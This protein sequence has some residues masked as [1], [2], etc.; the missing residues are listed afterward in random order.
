MDVKR[1]VVTYY[2]EYG[3]W[4]QIA[5]EL[6]SRI[7]L[8]NL[9]WNSA[10]HP[11]RTIHS[12]EIDLKRFTPD[13][14]PQ[15]M[16]HIQYPYLNLYFVACDDSETYRNNVRKQIKDWLDTVTSKKNQE[17]LIV[18]VAG[19][20]S[21]KN[22]ASFLRMRSSVYDK[23]KA[24]FNTPKKD[25]CATIRL[26]DTEAS[27]AE[28]WGDFLTK[29]KEGIMSSFDL[30]VAK[31]EED[32]RRLDSQRQ[33]PGWNY[34]TFFMFKEGLSHVFETMGLYDEA[35]RQYDELEA[36][37]FQVLRDK[38]LAWF[39]HFG[40]MD[41][42]DDSADLLDFRKKTYRDLI[43][44]NAI[45]L[46]DFRCYL[47][48][49]QCHMLAKLNHPVEIC[50]RAQ[51]F[52]L[53]MSLALRDNKQSLGK[54]FI[55]SWIFSSCMNV[56]NECEQMMQMYAN[57][58][59]VVIPYN[60]AK[61]ELLFAARRQ[62]DYLGVAHGHL[63]KELPFIL[64]CNSSDGEEAN[65]D[66][67]PV[68]ITYQRLKDGLASRES[69][70]KLY[71]T[72]TT[73]AIRACDLS[74]RKRIE[75]CLHADVGALRFYREKYDEASR[76]LESILVRHNYRGWT[77]IENYLY[78][79]NAV[80]N[81]HLGNHKKYVQMCI[82]LLRNRRELA[83]EQKNF[84]TDELLDSSSKLEEVI[85]TGMEPFF[86]VKQLSLLESSEGDES[87]RLE[88]EIVNS[89][90]K[91]LKI[92]SL[93]VRLVSQ[94]TL[95]RKRELTTSNTDLDDLLFR[96]NDQSLPVGTSKIL[97]HCTI[98]TSGI[99][100]AE[101]CRVQVGN[102]AF[103][104]DLS[105]ISRKIKFRVHEPPSFL[106]IAISQPRDVVLGEQETC[107]VQVFTHQQPINSGKL[108]FLPLSEGFGIVKREAISCTVRE[109]DPETENIS[110]DS[111]QTL[112]LKMDESGNI[113]LPE[114]DAHR[115]LELNIPCATPPN[116]S[117]HR[118]QVHID[119]ETKR[120]AKLSSRTTGTV[121]V[122]IPVDAQA[123]P[124]WRKDCFYLCVSISCNGAQPARL[125]RGSLNAL[126]EGFEVDPCP[127]AKD[128][129]ITLFPQQRGFLLFKVNRKEHNKARTAKAKFY[130]SATYRA[131]QTEIQLWLFREVR[132]Q[133]KDSGIGHY[134]SLAVEQLEP[135]LAG[136]DYTT[137]GLTETMSLAPPPDWQ[138]LERALEHHDI[139]AKTGVIDVLKKFFNDHTKV[140]RAELASSTKFEDSS[141]SFSME[142]PVVKVVM[143]VEFA[144]IA[145]TKF[146]HGQ[147]V[148]CKLVISQSEHWATSED[149]QP[150]EATEADDDSRDFYYEVEG[151]MDTWLISGRK[152]QRFRSKP[153]DTHVFE[154]TLLPLKTGQ[155]HLPPVRVLYPLSLASQQ[156]DAH[157]AATALVN[158]AQ[159][160][161][162]LPA[163]SSN[164]FFVEQ[165]TVAPPP[166][167]GLKTGLEALKEERDEPLA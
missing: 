85:V 55:E 25:R 159:Q 73:R 9:H 125:I 134:A 127:T 47:F 63:P 119:Y 34:C 107:L 102:L 84:Y 46:F 164:T 59:A 133:L 82:D 62:L 113:Q 28:I 152:K 153:G 117:T 29:M 71:T 97:L 7:P 129:C 140:T 87:I 103:V 65:G 6:S 165:R 51:I 86:S 38:A 95:G 89:F 100:V 52:I 4:P 155:L 77:V 115:V 67:R 106:R 61:S 74:N 54:Y 166:P 42:G 31:Y 5:D 90:D 16:L 99:Y 22:S 39:G 144:P 93:E 78:Q 1:V 10:Q 151:D 167:T 2:D 145:K 141:V 27:E 30:H 158:H 105:I 122:W 121:R 91:E 18:Y 57:E 13:T 33:M 26:H 109:V 50:Q 118:V 14:S 70:D 123:W 20:I 69:F 148:P 146:Y 3:L 101:L 44:Q 64:Y 19:Q 96:A 45:S 116:V 149:A 66:D 111:Q 160:V 162:V 147:P 41:E 76:I 75:Y 92:K 126:S 23:I 108:S 8:K 40:G 15:H 114:V 154:V 48:A 81:K 56:V 98:S 17:W 60:A 138:V 157:H 36:S 142:L 161:V 150:I 49:R 21:A 58:P 104:H 156:G 37:F 12:L 137:Y 135:F 139:K 128:A 143:S 80:S 53:S 83:E 32:I 11:A 24:D 72:L 43:M 130:F 35:L 132:R 88:L 131:L 163:S 120:G 136:L 112:E 79:M 110:D 124:R 68:R 94:N